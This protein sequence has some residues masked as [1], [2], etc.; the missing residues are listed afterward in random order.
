M[1]LLVVTNLFPN[2]SE[3][4]RSTFNERQILALAE[5]EPVTVVCPVSWT[6]KV[7][8]WRSGKLG[9]L[10]RCRDWRGIPVRYPTYHFVPRALPWLRGWSMALSLLPACAHAIRESRPRAILATWAYPDGFAAGLLGRHFGLPVHIKVHG[11]DVEA[12]DEPGWAAGLARRGLC[13]AD[14]VVSVSRYLRDRLVHHGVPEERVAVVHN[15]IDSDVFDLRDQAPLRTEL[16][17][18]PHRRYVLYVGNLKE[19]K[20]LLDLL[21]PVVV[22]SCRAAGAEI[23]VVGGGPLQARLERE[24]QSR[25]LQRDVRLLGRKPPAEIARWMNASDGLCLPS[26]HEG[27]P[28]V[29]LEARSCGVPVVATRV[30]GIPEVVSAESGVL[31]DARQPPSLAAG[32]AELFGRRWDRETIRRTSP[33]GTWAESASALR[34]ATQDRAG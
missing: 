9:A 31:V 32:L 21:H 1:S 16:G 4:Q 25:G 24:I 18:A 17:L 6:R 11:S 2:P 28:N 13:R 27:I 3:P 30:G 22:E 20:G 19:D 10:G 5:L 26:H 23:L 14:G 12:L 8:L 15:G 29:I 33:A 34:R 7:D